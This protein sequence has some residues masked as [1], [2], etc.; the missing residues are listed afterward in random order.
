MIGRRVYPDENGRLHMEPGDF[1]FQ[2][3]QWFGVTPT[4]MV[5]GLRAHKVTEHEDGT[6]TVSP[7][8]LCRG[9]NGRTERNEEW[10][11][12]LERGVWREV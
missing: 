5:A 10:H 7:S 2:S 3:N 6:I 1:W 12:Y 8:I 4:G 11:G 9:Y